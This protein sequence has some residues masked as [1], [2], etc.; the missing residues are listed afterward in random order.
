M[1]TRVT[2]ERVATFVRR[3]TTAV[4]GRVNEREEMVFEQ[5]RSSFGPAAGKP[6]EPAGSKASPTGPEEKGEIGG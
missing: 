3:Q 1:G 6:R 2:L 4:N 5:G